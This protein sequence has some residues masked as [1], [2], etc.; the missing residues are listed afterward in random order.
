V[1][2]GECRRFL[3]A[4][5]ANRFGEIIESRL[6]DGTRSAVGGDNWPPAVS[7]LSDMHLSKADVI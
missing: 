5:S 3:A 4:A 2:V 1:A 6:T 7:Q